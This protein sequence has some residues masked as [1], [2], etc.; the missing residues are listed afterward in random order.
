M[1]LIEP[2]QYGSVTRLLLMDKQE[3]S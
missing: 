3:F 1:V 2:T